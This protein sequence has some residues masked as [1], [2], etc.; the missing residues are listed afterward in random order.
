MYDILIKNGRV[1]DGT[2]NPWFYADVA[3]TGGRIVAIKRRLEGARVTLDVKGKIVCPGFIDAHTHSDH[4]LLA[5]PT[6]DSKVHQGVTTEVV[7]NCGS[8][9]AP[10]LG[11]A[12]EAIVLQQSERLGGFEVDWTTT[13]AYLSKLEKQG[14]AV[15]VASLIG[16]GTLRICVMGHAERPATP[17]ER[18]AMRGLLEENLDEG[19][20]GL[21]TGLFYAPQSFA[22]T[23][24]VIDVV[25]GLK[26]KE[27]LYVTHVRD[28][29]NY[30]VGIL[31]ALEEALQTASEAEAPLHISHI[32]LNGIAAWHNA[33]AVIEMIEKARQSGMDITAD[34]YSY[35][36]CGGG[37]CG[38]IMPRWALEGG[39]VKVL[40]RLSHEPT[41]DRIAREI[42]A[43]FSR[44]G[45]PELHT[46]S[47]YRPNPAFEGMTLESVAGI[48]GEPPEYAVLTMLEKA[49]AGWVSAILN[50]DDVETFMKAPWVMIG[51]DGGSLARSGRAGGGKPHPRN[52]GCFPRVIAVYSREK[53]LFPVEDAIRKMTSLPA[54]RFG[55]MDRGLL[56]EGFWAD[57]VV[58]DPCLLADA[59]TFENPHR[60]PV[61]IDY[62][63]VNGQ[64]V[65]DKGEHTGRL[66][67][68]ALRRT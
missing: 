60:F 7:G 1:I 4:V 6:A 32:Q 68:K 39:R 23:D 25:K 63:I 19:A 13:G 67:G 52:F 40:E 12:R 24:E 55:L 20:F 59:A 33:G 29:G 48:L 56:K 44:R 31:A 65:I 47:V 51:S 5:N 21:S 66:P 15:N 58:F 38:S 64:V 62:V 28:E 17:G 49:D 61:G 54:Q 50:D 35:T 26:P 45:G 3:V 8:S 41:R 30:T 37:I 18:S 53:G 2:G 43:T 57:A 9:P 11:P 27:A 46:F 14:V 36:R 16:F 34:E 22:A 10:L 42:A